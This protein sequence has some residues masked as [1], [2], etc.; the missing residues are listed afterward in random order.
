MF[1]IG[2]TLFDGLVPFVIGTNSSYCHLVFKI[3]IIHFYFCKALLSVLSTK[4][5]KYS[6]MAL[7]LYFDMV[8][9]QVKNK[10]DCESRNMKMCIKVK[11]CVK[12]V[13]LGAPFGGGCGERMVIPSRNLI[14]Q[15]VPFITGQ[16]H[17]FSAICF[18]FIVFFS[19]YIC[20][21]QKHQY[22]INI[23]KAK[24]HNSLKLRHSCH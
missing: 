17:F 7:I 11:I 10:L 14:F 21:K 5:Q 15:N 16:T 12:D 18:F 2:T 13:Q 20:V 23:L 6:G 3:R 1:N 8:T 24:I 22:E 19:V 4:M 9:N